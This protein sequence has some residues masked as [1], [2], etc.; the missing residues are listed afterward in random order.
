MSE[1]VVRPPPEVMPALVTPFDIDGSLDL[2]AHHHNVAALWERGARG[3]L[4]GGSSGEGPF[5]EPGERAALLASAR[6]VA[7]DAYLLGGVNG[8]SVRLAVSQLDEIAAAGADA[9]LVITP[10]TLSRDDDAAVRRFYEQVAETSPLPVL[11]YTVPRWT[12]YSLPVDMAAVLAGRAG[13]VGIKDS[14]GEPSRVG[15]LVASLHG[16]PFLVYAGASAAIA[17]SV[18]LGATGAITASAN[19]AFDLV[20]S[21][22]ASVRSDSDPADAQARLGEM[23]AAV[24]RWG[25]A[26]TKAAA[27]AAGLRAG[28][29]RLPLR[30][31]PD[32]VAAEVAAL[33][34]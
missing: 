27:A 33:L 5:L 14:G 19:Y 29:P 26:G 4:V 6:R 28:W 30:P 25:L 16:A 23:S 9:G 12:G 24:E 17:E 3:F 8:E 31:L 34:G 15:D 10:T 32:T 2:A 21:V 1:I 18:R 11:L 13:I 22:V 7:A 20:A